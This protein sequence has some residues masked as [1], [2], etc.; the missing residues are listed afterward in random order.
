MGQERPELVEDG[1]PEFIEGGIDRPCERVVPP[2]EQALYRLHLIVLL[3]DQPGEHPRIA[4]PPILGAVARRLAPLLA[5]MV[6]QEVQIP[7]RGPGPI[8]AG[9]EL[10]QEHCPIDRLQPRIIE[11]CQVLDGRLP[12]GDFVVVGRDEPPRTVLPPGS[13]TYQRAGWA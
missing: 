8:E 5:C 7:D 6:Q 3:A 11:L 12:P 10:L 1:R 2:L 4:S 9:E 13:S